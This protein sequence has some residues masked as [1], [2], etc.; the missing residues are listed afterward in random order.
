MT[1]WESKAQARW[2]HSPAGVKALG[3]KKNVAEWDASTKGLK[4]PA[5]VGKKKYKMKVD[6]KIKSYGWM[7]PKTNQIKINV[8]SHKGDKAELASTIKHELMHVNHPKRTEREVTKLTAKTKI[9]PAEQ[10]ELLKKLHRTQLAKNVSSLKKRF[11]MK[12]GEEVVPGS[13]INR[14]KEQS[15]N[16]AQPSDGMSVAKRVAISGLV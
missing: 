3:G 11:K 6:N 2:G 14:A 7:D 15:R 16:V 5:R 10:R 4:L 13:F 12:P 9:P 8:K 1:P